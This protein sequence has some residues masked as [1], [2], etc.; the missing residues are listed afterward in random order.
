MKSEEAQQDLLELPVLDEVVD[1]DSDR[2]K[3]ISALDELATL[4]ERV[5]RRGEALSDEEYDALKDEL[6]AKLVQMFDEMAERM[7]YIIPRMVE[8]TLRAHLDKKSER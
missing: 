8:E 2:A 7:K 3:L 6:N 5:P 1:P 4:I